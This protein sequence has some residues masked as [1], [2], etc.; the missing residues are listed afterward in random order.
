[1]ICAPLRPAAVNGLL[2]FYCGLVCSSD[3][4]ELPLIHGDLSIAP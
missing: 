2:L 3:R 1:M 4:Q